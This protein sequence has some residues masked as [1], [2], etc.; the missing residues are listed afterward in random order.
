MLFT[1]LLTYSTISSVH[2]GMGRRADGD[3][4]WLIGGFKIRISAFVY[5]AGGGGKGVL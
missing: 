1:Y 2:V 4:E 5:P 3:G